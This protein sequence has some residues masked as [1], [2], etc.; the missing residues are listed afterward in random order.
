M[1]KQLVLIVLLLGSLLPLSAQQFARIYLFDDFMKAQILFRNKARTSAT[2]NYDASNK[3]MLFLQG[4]ELMEVTNTASIDTVTVGGR[5]LVPAAKGFYE[6]VKLDNGVVYIDWLL[7]DVN[8]GS[9]GALGSVTQGSVQNLQMSNL[10]LNATEMYTPYA[11]QKIGSTDVYKRKSDNTYYFTAKNKQQKIK[12][13]KQLIKL[14]PEHEDE[15]EAYV[16]QE[17]VEMQDI[18][19]VLMLLNFCLGLDK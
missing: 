10:G 13:V 8:I 7:K 6:V 9:K 16:K 2:L 15:I 4:E 14:Y 12:S 19:K 1:K 17:D 5:K 11:P 18:P 3:V